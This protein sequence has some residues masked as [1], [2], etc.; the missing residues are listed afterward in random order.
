V[1]AIDEEPAVSELETA[2]LR[3]D[4]Y[5]R[6]HHEDEDAYEEEL[7]ERA[8]DGNAPEAVFHASLASTLRRMNARGTL[9]VWLTASDVERIRASGLKTV[10]MEWNPADQAPLDLP[11]DTD[12]LITRI[13]LPLEGVRTVE[14][15]VYSIDGT[16]LKRMPDVLFD[17]ADGAA[18]ACCEA[19]LARTAASAP[20]TITKLFAVTDTERRLIVEL[21]S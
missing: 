6:Q 12:L 1:D 17:R 18:Y 9:D 15:E 19:E 10:F 16:L 20:K 5:V 4:D 3:L 14:A 7:F 21:P 11:P 13:P 2:L 8:L